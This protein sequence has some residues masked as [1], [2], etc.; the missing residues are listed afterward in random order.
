LTM[1]QGTQIE[2]IGKHTSSLNNL[3]Y[4]L[5]ITNHLSYRT[6]A[7]LESI[8]TVS[9]PP[10]QLNSIDSQ[11]SN[12][13]N[14]HCTLR[15]VSHSA[16]PA[17]RKPSPSDL[18][19]LKSQNRSPIIQCLVCITWLNRFFQKLFCSILKRLLNTKKT[20]DIRT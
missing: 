1:N 13:K 16:S 17:C 19:C 2:T 4:R 15:K 9:R 14:I 18:A 6:T 10:C 5:F 3:S 7:A 11:T 20:Y 12:S 8:T